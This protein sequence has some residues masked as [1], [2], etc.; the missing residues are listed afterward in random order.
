M[1]IIIP[2]KLWVYLSNFYFF[3]VMRFQK[4]IVCELFLVSGNGSFFANLLTFNF[5]NNC[6]CVYSSGNLIFMKALIRND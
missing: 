4:K 1:Y 2:H 6:D 5:V 3:H